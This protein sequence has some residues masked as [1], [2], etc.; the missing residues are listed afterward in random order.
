MSWIYTFLYVLCNPPDNSLSSCPKSIR[1]YTFRATLS[2]FSEIGMRSDTFYHVPY[3]PLMFFEWFCK[4]MIRSYTFRAT[5]SQLCETGIRSDTFWTRSCTQNR[6]MWWKVTRSVTFR[7][8]VLRIRSSQFFC[9]ANEPF[10]LERLRT[11]SHIY[12]HIFC[13]GIWLLYSASEI[14]CVS[15]HHGRS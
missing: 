10:S 1:S 14:R 5:L 11:Q 6:N 4:I 13:R 3:T 15:R 9:V 12:R 7:A 8:T 2:Q